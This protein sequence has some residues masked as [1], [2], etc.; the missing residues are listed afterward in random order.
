MKKNIQS[1]LPLVSV[2]TPTFN[3][4][5]T[6][7]RSI[8]SVLSQTY[9]NIELIIVN[10][11]SQDNTV[12]VVKGIKDERIQIYSLS[13]KRNGSIARNFGIKHA[14]GQY[15]AF[16]DDDDEWIDKKIEK[17]IQYLQNKNKEEW[18]AVITSHYN[19]KG[20]SWN[21]IILNK[22]GD[23]TKEILLMQVSLGAGSGLLI[24]K[25]ALEEIGFFNEAY[26]RHQ[27]MEVVLKYLR[28]YKLAIVKEPLFR[29]HGHSFRVNTKTSIADKLLSAKEIFLNDFK[30][31]IQKFDKK[32]QDKIYAR[33]WLQISRFYSQEGNRKETIKY[34][35]KS[36]SYSFLFSNR[37]KI[38]PFETYFLIIFNILK[39]FL[40]K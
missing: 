8:K 18:K 37:Y 26:L 10:D 28:K 40:F 35:K 36:L 4:E 16:L 25:S 2:I 9:P 34:L 13:K 20:N 32:T 3:G 31:D 5:K 30:K 21:S 19:Q 38:M 24:E 17:Q 6:I 27:D 12:E 33:Q 11:S 39:S 23:L 15:I 22:E 7:K 1:K 29:V 14:K